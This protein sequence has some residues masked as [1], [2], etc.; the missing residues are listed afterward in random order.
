MV[1][2]RTNQSPGPRVNM[3]VRKTVGVEMSVVA[4]CQAD[5]SRKRPTLENETDTVVFK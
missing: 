2:S 3:T 4:L 1:S 5:S